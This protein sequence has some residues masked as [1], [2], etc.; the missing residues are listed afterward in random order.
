MAEKYD[1]EGLEHSSGPDRTRAP[2]QFRGPRP[3]GL[4]AF[5]WFGNSMYVGPRQRATLTRTFLGPRRD[6]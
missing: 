5:G 2:T 6:Y 1:C 3:H 4:R